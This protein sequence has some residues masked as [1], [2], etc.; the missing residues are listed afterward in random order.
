MTTSNSTNPQNRRK[1]TGFQ[2]RFLFVLAAIL[3]IFSGITVSIIYHHEM[4]NLEANAFEKTELVMKSIEANR[5]YVQDVLRP[6]MYRELGEKRFILEAMSSSYISRMIMENFN[7]K[8]HGFIY[9]RVAT[10]AKNPEYEA[11]P[12]ET[13]MIERFRK[14]PELAEWQG[15]IEMESRKYFM[16]FQPVVFQKS[17]LNCHGRPEDAPDEVTTLYGKTRGYFHEADKISGVIGVGMPIDLNLERIKKFAIALFAGVVPSIFIVYIIISTFFN[18]YIAGNLRTILS[19]FR[20]NIKDDEGRSIFENSQAI[21]EIDDLTATARAIAEH[22]HHNQNTLEKYADEILKSKNLLQS[23]FDGI[24]DPVVLMD[25]KGK[26]KVVNKA[27]RQRY[28]LSM[29]QII[30]RRPGDFLDR[31]CCPLACCED[32]FVSLPDHPISRE[33]QM[34]GGEIFLIYFYPI[35]VDGR[36]TESVVCYVKDITEQRKMETKIQHTEKIASIG[37]LAAGIAHEINNPLG[38]ILCHLDLIKDDPTLSPEVRADLETIE[39]HAGNCRTIISDLLKFAHQHAS[40]KEPIS[41]NALVEEVAFMVSGQFRKQQ[42]DIALHLDREIPVVT[43][44][45]DKMKQVFLNM[46]LN[47][48]QAIGENGTITL[49][50]RY[51]SDSRMVQIVVEDSGPGIPADILDKIFDPFFTT[52]PPGKGT[53]LGLSISYGIIQDHNGD[54]TAESLPGRP[55][56][57]VISLPAQGEES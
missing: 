2:T 30:D 12:L 28:N 41:I 49:L 5:D 53:G 16:R 22:I 26:I 17:C 56:R 10:N 31:N 47:S 43:V 39:K 48:A 50:S 3:I 55:T 46:L 8:S 42:I 21:D 36:D 23:V 9:R 18:R 6:T 54:I 57:F 11:N 13:E 38:V 33:I 40:V 7:K 20:N 51:N 4:D 35:R 24:T 37:Q 45:A 1:Y 25:R 32:I 44:D 29:D 52:K 34:T 19:Y 15:I 27:F 14:D